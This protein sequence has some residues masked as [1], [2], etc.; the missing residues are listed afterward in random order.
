MIQSLDELAALLKL[1]RKQGVTDIKY[2]GISVTFG[3][4]PRKSRKDDESSDDI[5][6]DELSPEQLMYFSVGGPVDENQKV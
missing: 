4:L 2:G 1:C 5:P 3:D 6:T